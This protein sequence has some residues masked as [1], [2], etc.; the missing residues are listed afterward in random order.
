V[1]RA[2]VSDVSVIDVSGPSRSSR[3]SP[4][5]IKLTAMGLLPAPRPQQG[6]RDGARRTGCQPRD[7]SRVI[8][9]GLAGPEGPPMGSVR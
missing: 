1:S 9:M 6:D 3:W 8:A 5:T 2:S 4:S 7:H